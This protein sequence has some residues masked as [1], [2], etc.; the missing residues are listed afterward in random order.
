MKYNV[1]IDIGDDEISPREDSLLYAKI[2]GFFE[3][4]CM[5]IKRVDI[6]KVKENS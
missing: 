2:W 6:K 5:D 4:H 1:F 3:E